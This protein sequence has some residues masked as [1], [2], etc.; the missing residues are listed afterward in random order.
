MTPVLA[1]SH[2]AATAVI[3]VPDGRER[4]AVF[5]G[6][7]VPPS[8]HDQQLAYGAGRTIAKAGFTMRQGGYNG[9][10]ELAARGAASVGGQVVA[11]TLAGKQEW[12]LANRYV[13]QVVEL[14]DMGQRLTYFLDDA[15]VVVAMGGG[16]GTLH[17]LT[18][19]IW[20]AGNI[21]QIPIICVGNTATKLTAYLRRE[22]WLFETPTRPL[23]F[24]T[25]VTNSYSFRESFRRLTDIPQGIEDVEQL[26][27][28]ERHVRRRM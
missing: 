2:D 5:F 12:G 27:M 13:T 15:E 28:P 9:L 21:R 11:V 25:A 3:P 14:P 24:L 18:A 22:K 26:E 10:M 23:S 7:V 16:V 6:G 8:H 20:Y 1:T 4:V 17:E 19:A